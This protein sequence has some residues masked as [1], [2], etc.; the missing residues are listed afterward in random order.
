MKLCEMIK[1]MQHYADGG[2][3]EIRLENNNRDNFYFYKN[4][5]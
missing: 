5:L 3:V 2:D 4:Y 1:V